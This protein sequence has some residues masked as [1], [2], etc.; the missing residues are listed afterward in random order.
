MPGSN[1]VG[2]PTAGRIGRKDGDGRPEDGEKFLES[3]W[4]ERR[5]EEKSEDMRTTSSRCSYRGEARGAS[6]AYGLESSP[7]GEWL[8][9]IRSAGGERRR[10]E[11]ERGRWCWVMAAM[12]TGRG[13]TRTGCS[14]MKDMVVRGR[15]RAIWLYFVMMSLCK[16]IGYLA[17]LCSSRWLLL[18]ICWLHVP[19]LFGWLYCARTDLIH[20]RRQRDEWTVGVCGEAADASAK[21]PTCPSVRGQTHGPP[22]IHPGQCFRRP[23]I[24]VT[25]TLPQI[26]PYINQFLTDLNLIPSQ[27]QIGFY[28]GLVVSPLSSLLVTPFSSCN[29]RNP[30]LPSSSCSSY[31]N[32][33][34]YPVHSVSIVSTHPHSCSRHVW[35]PSGDHNWHCRSFN[36]DHPFRSYFKS[37]SNPDYALFRFARHLWV[38]FLTLTQSLAGTF[39]GT[40]AVLHSVLGELTDQSNQALAFPIYG[41]FWPLG[42]IVG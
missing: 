15:G 20:D 40:A 37:L 6:S 1:R 31:T 8:A 26:F 11:W 7:S 12:R 25:L 30:A 10:T 42:N 2:S 39:S 16:R 36:I 41:L 34:T 18:S 9:A 5:S 4:G 21:R 32:G 27:S 24:R 28:S 17:I 33:L 19:R 13:A 35:P 38:F 3:L 29:P 22:H 14:G 23:L